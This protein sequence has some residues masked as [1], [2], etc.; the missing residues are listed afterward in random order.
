MG[1]FRFWSRW[2]DEQRAVAVKIV[3][4][5]VSA[6]TVFALVS[7]LSYMFTWKT[8]QS[9]LTDPAMMDPGVGVSNS[10]GK[11]GFRFGSFLVGRCFGL[12]SFAL[13]FILAV[14]MP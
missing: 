14:M 12:G 6:F 5:L 10:A 3:A 13:I 2:D 4:V 7:S 8:D 1:I 11:L 9:L